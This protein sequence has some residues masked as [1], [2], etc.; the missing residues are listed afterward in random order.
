SNNDPLGP[1]SSFR[2]TEFGIL[3][4]GQ[5]PPLMTAGPLSGC[6]SN[7]ARAQSDPMHSL[8]PVQHFID[9]FR[10]LKSSPERI[11]VSAIAAPT[12]PFS[13][14][15]DPQEG[16]AALEHSCASS[17]GTFG[18]PAVRIKQLVDA[19]GANGGMTS[20]CEDSYADAITLIA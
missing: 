3:C 9:A 8:L 6:V 11:R 18:D 12:D 13:V 1:L 17:N 10:Q 5:P 19:F 16:F 15:I 2:C 20:V 14:V 7:D 4:N